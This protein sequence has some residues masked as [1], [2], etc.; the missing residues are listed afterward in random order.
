MKLRRLGGFTMIE[1]IMIM[2]IIG[3][4]AGIILVQYPASIRRTRDTQ[5]RSDL[6]QYKIALEKYANVNNGLYPGRNGGVGLWVAHGPTG[7]GPGAVY[8]C[9]DDLGLTICPADPRDD[10]AVCENDLVCKYWYQGNNCNT[11]S[12]CATHYVLRARL[13]NEAGWFVAC[14]NGNSGI[15][16]ETTDF[17][18]LDGACPTIP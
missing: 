5:R 10:Q 14:Q 3:V 15:V 4:M 2:S 18:A 12:A 11:G 1:L 8:L 9:E 13:E 7:A 16:S 6:S 17:D